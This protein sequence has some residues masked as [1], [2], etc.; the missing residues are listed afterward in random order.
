M[1]NACHLSIQQGAWS[2]AGRIFLNAIVIATDWREAQI[3]K[4][5]LL[6][7]AV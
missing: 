1:S 6:V 4:Q 7:V 5:A 2:S 3:Y